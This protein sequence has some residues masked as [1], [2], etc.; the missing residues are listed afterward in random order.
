MNVN[1]KSCILY[2][3]MILYNPDTIA[4]VE[5]LAKKKIFFSLVFSEKK[6][7]IRL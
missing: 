5:K 4:H 3:D 2:L 7:R 1:I 6:K